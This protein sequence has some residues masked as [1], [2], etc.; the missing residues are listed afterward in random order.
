MCRQGQAGYRARPPQSERALRRWPHLRHDSA[1]RSGMAA[2][3]RGTWADVGRTGADGQRRRVAEGRTPMPAD[4]SAVQALHTS[5]TLRPTRAPLTQSSQPPI[6]TALRLSLLFRGDRRKCGAR[7]RQTIPNIWTSGTD[8]P[9]LP[10]PASE[11]TGGQTAYTTGQL[12]LRRR[13]EPTS[14][15]FSLP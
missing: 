12:V 9:D 4:R 1:L 2:H 6:H 5:D 13:L 3:P 7:N 11:R 15:G 10:L 8:K 14:A